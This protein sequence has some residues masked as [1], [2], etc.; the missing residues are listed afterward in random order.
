MPT[1]GESSA[2]FIGVVGENCT[3]LKIK[4]VKELLD[5]EGNDLLKQIR[6]GGN[7]VVKDNGLETKIADL[8]RQVDD[9]IR[10]VRDLSS[11]SGVAGPV[12]KDGEKGEKG[13]KGDDGF[14]GPRGKSIEKLKEIKDVN[15]DGLEEG[16]VL[17]WSA[18][19]N[20]WVVNVLE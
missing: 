8:S 7:V 5:H 9:L 10:Q 12:G 20:Q 13:D 19:N 11:R 3:F 2:R 14:Q 17:T 16:A 4:G 18:K 15:L 1:A 6:S